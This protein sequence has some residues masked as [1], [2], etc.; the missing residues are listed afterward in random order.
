MS[1]IFEDF[2]FRAEEPGGDKII[3]YF[4]DE[5]A[6]RRKGNALS[7]SILAI[8]CALRCLSV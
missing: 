2:D 6:R 4:I 5:V 1:V 8:E 7:L 3:F